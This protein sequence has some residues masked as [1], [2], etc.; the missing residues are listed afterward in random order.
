MRQLWVAAV[1]VASAVAV[2]C[3]GEPVPPGESVKSS[4]QRVVA[5]APAGDVAAAVAGNTDF[6]F[7]LYRE[8]AKEQKDNLFI[9]PY[10]IST[11]LAMAYA[12]SAGSTA[13]AF[14]RTLRISLASGAYHR[15]KNDI[16]RQLTSRGQGA[17][18]ADGK[19]FRLTP[20]NQLFAQNG[21]SLETPFLDTLAVEYGAGV[22]TM[23]FERSP[24]P[25]RAA[26]NTWV[27]QKTEDRIQDLLGA[28]SITSDTRVVLVNAI[29]FN[30]A[31]QKAFEQ[32]ATAER[33]FAT[34]AES[35][36]NVSTMHAPAVAARGGTHE[37][38]E[39][40][41]LPYDGGELSMLVLAPPVGQ[42]G[43]L[44]AKLSDTWLKAAVAGLK[45]ESLDLYLPKFEVKKQVG[46]KTP[47]S[48]LGLAE[49]F[50]GG[51]D[52]SNLSKAEQLKISDVLH[53]AFV[54]VNESGTEAA[55]ATAVIFERTTAAPESR[56]VKIDR[57]FL[58]L[59]RDHATGEI[60]FL[61]RITQPTAG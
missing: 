58:F 44:E 60:V 61:G 30:A 27:E 3:V 4:Q 7:G 24:E 54:K 10:S 8:V 11:A 16:D 45:S 19:A 15:A 20:A 31:W 17:K 38:V 40:V 21:F 34:G 43:A 2:G 48:A 18:A 25:S 52:F 23:D 14:E 46:L 56:T 51:A 12:G 50:T 41:E 13:Q 29:Y 6:A 35:T 49:A 42:L 22:R 28:G 26:I 57:P 1:A 5:A 59:I 53:Q 32:S 55:A 47:L 37:G 9:S 39:V 36:V 33:P